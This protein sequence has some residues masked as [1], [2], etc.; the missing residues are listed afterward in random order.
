MGPVQR[1]RRTTPD[2][3]EPDPELVRLGHGNRD[4]GHRRAPHPVRAGRAGAAVLAAVLLRDVRDQPDRPIRTIRAHLPFSLT[5]WSFT[6][7]VGTCVLDVAAARPSP[8]P[9]VVLRSRVRRPR[10]S[11]YSPRRHAGDR[12]GSS[13]QGSSAAVSAFARN[14]RKR[15][16]G[17]FCRRTSSSYMPG[18]VYAHIASRAS[19]RVTPA[20]R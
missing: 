18:S 5:W 6:F 20:R 13:R 2:S 15:S 16:S 3:G 17:H 19:F 11:L 8:L 1:P 7:P 4:R 9:R 10:G 14:S 12:S